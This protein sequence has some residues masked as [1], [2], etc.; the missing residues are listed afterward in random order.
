M[1]L[2]LKRGN[3]S[4]T[5]EEIAIP[6]RN[7]DYEGVK[8]D[9]SSISAYG[10]E[11]GDL[12]L[13]LFAGEESPNRAHRR[14]E[15]SIELKL[16]SDENPNDVLHLEEQM[17]NETE[18]LK[19]SGVGNSTKSGNT[20][21]NANPWD[22]PIE[23]YEVRP[24]TVGKAI[25]SRTYMENVEE[26]HHPVLLITFIVVVAT[27][28]LELASLG[29]IS[30]QKVVDVQFNLMKFQW[31]YIGV[32]IVVLVDAILVNMLHKKKL[33]LILLALF[34]PFVYPLQ[35]GKHTN[36]HSV[37]GHIVLWSSFIAYA[38]LILLIGKA[39]NSY[40]GIVQ[41]SDE[42][43]R[44][45]AAMALDQDIYGVNVGSQIIQ[46]M[47]IDYA[48]YEQQNGKDVVELMGR[49][50]VYLEK[51]RF[52]DGGIENIETVFIFVKN[53]TGQ[54]VLTKVMLGK[55][56]LTDKYLEFYWNEVIK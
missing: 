54:Y 8:Q 21:K 50:S 41:L 43:V 5:T 55:Q 29:W 39:V 10:V 28:V 18:R 15:E 23:N 40:G 1:G 13:G 3:K 34:L 7:K 20:S 2:E 45:E 46:N 22:N 4:E 37:T 12:G 56:E 48:T 36:G 19:L 31:L 17:Q 38:S 27:F 52:V 44:H 25:D 51:N 26:E 6:A 42:K 9:G 30:A 16:Y 32:S 49:D 33:S 47:D 53:S 24:R 14:E 35:R 11:S